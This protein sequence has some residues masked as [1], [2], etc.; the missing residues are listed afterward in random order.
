MILGLSVDDIVYA[1]LICIFC[2]LKYYCIPS[3]LHQRLISRFVEVLFRVW[4][5]NPSRHQGDAPMMYT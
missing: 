1:G 2:S 3:E 4:L 5:T